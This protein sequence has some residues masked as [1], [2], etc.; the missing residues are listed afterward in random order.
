M[1]QSDLQA[2]I[3]ARNESFLRD[4]RNRYQEFFRTIESSPLT[5]E[6]VKAVVCLETECR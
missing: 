5:D 2:Y 6:Q 1:W 4:E 3:D